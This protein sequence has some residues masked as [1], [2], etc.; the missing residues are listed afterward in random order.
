MKG[1]KNLKRLWL[2]DTDV[3]DGTLIHVAELSSLEALWLNGT[4][5]SD[6][7]VNHL[8]ALTNLKELVVN[9]TEVT[10]KGASILRRALPDCER[11]QYGLIGSMKLYAKRTKI[12]K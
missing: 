3:H 2:N 8:V 5:I 6:T 12:N 9:E 1:L 11:V 10:E 7:G 4:Q